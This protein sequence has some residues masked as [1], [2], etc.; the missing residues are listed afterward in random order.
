[1]RLIQRPT[2]RSSK[3]HRRNASETSTLTATTT[4]SASIYQE[5]KF[6]T[7][8][9][10]AQARMD[11]WQR[12]V[13]RT[14]SRT[15]VRKPLH[16]RSVSLPTGP[17]DVDDYYIPNSSDDEEDDDDTLSGPDIH[18]LK[19]EV[20]R[21]VHPLKRESK[22]KPHPLKRESKREPHPLKRDSLV[23]QKEVAPRHHSQQSS[24]T[25]PER[26]P[27]PPPRPPRRSG[28]VDLDED[29]FSSIDSLL[30]VSLAL[31][32]VEQAL[33]ASRPP[34]VSRGTSLPTKS[35]SK[36]TSHVRKPSQGS[37]IFEC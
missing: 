6:L 3:G 21:E 30:D 1:M 27:P 23:V 8:E 22:R 36:K 15:I 32:E 25:L 26:D 33:K 7:P 19:R 4:S 37:Y 20:K 31:K 24:T 29:P 5:D 18:P 9:Q 10:L 17:V 16:A 13:R 11:L 28:P 35:V 14:I 12:P 2:Q 34:Q